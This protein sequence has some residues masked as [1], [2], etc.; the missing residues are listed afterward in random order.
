M[1]N[2]IFDDSALLRRRQN[3]TYAYNLYLNKIQNKLIINNP[4]NSNGD[5][6]VFSEY[7]PGVQTQYFEGLLGGR[8]MVSLGGIAP[9]LSMQETQINNSSSSPVVSDPVVPDPVVPDPVVPDPVPSDPPAYTSGTQLLSNPEFTVITDN[10]ASGWTST[11]GW[12]SYSYTFANSPTTV[13]N[14]P[15][16]YPISTSTGFVI[17]SFQS[18]TISQTIPI[19]SLVGINTITG[20]LNIVNVSNRNMT[21]TFTFQIQYKNSTGLV[22][23]TTTTNSIQAP[24]TW[25][26]YTLTLT[27]NASP[28]FDLIKSITVNITS[29]DVGYWNGHHGP[30]MDYCRLTVS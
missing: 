12:D 13:M 10:G 24:A 4:Q 6:S 7:K 21:D 28:N 5:A 17:F 18:A 9:I 1:S 16:G 3:Q 8:E 29:I 11:Q 14:M 22:L 27:R 25:T 20:V 26:D 23:Y 30:A 2:R 15:D 19:I